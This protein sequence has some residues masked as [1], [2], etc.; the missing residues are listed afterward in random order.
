MTI[1]IPADIYDRLIEH[2]RSELPNECCGLAEYD[3]AAGT[4]V[5]ARQLVNAEPSPMR[6]AFASPDLLEIPRIEER[7]LVPVIYHSHVASEPSPSQTDLT[8]AAGWP[9][10]PW[11]IAGPMNGDPQL[12]WFEIEDGAVREHA[13]E[14]A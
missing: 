13:V 10:V 6:F 3:P 5:A 7:G 2:A 8:F 1:S 14:R 4:V 9:G 12:R 11:L